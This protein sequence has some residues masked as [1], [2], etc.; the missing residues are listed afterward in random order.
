MKRQEFIKN[1]SLATFLLADGS[2]LPAFGEV[3][4]AK[5]PRLRFV[6]A[7]DGHFG[8]PKTDYQNYFE[9]LV[10]NVNLQHKQQK[11]DFCVINGDI[12]HDQTDLLATAKS[13]FDDFLM[14]YFV[15]QGNHDHA[16]PEYWERIWGVPLNYDYVLGNNAFLFGTTSNAEGKYLPPDIQWFKQKL[17]EHKN[18]KNV[19]IF[20]H[21]TPVKWTDNAV[22]SPEFQ[23][24][25]RQH[26]N[27][28]A[29]FNGHDHDQEGIKTQDGVPYLFDA[30]FGG[31]WGTAYR[32]FRV[33]ELQSKNALL[34]YIM[35]PVTKIN[36]VTV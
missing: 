6:V 16:T 11:L 32:G 19:F 28:R 30:H 23:E 14:P 3:F 31:N 26:K 35:N 2:I 17:D 4:S 29:I 22:D 12:I 8:Q 21:I 27:V 5:K 25:I 7:S 34:T 33:V 36:E 18:K 9:T 20:I 1:I 15:T 10:K 13:I 24:L